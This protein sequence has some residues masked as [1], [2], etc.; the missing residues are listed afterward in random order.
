M[1]R[2]VK[3]VYRV[4]ADPVN[5]TEMFKTELE[6][7]L[8]QLMEEEASDD[9]EYLTVEQNILIPDVND[10]TDSRAIGTVYRNRNTSM[11]D[12]RVSVKIS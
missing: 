4:N 9:V 7:V 8:N 3:R 11:L 5:E 12:V 10:V 1:S 2:V 6:R